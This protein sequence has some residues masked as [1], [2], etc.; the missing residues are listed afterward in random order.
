MLV[1]TLYGGRSYARN[2]WGNRTRLPR[3][4][5]LVA[6]DVLVRKTLSE[7]Q[8]FIY[9]GDGK[10]YNLTNGFAEDSLTLS[11]RLETTIATGRFYAVL[12]PSLSVNLKK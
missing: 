3:E 2:S 5:N 10:L 9:A 1:P 4:L 6:G 12:R 11:K 7:N 8:I